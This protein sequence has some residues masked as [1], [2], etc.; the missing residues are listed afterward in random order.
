WF[1]SPLTVIRLQTPLMLMAL[2]LTLTI[3]RSYFLQVAVL[4]GLSPFTVKVSPSWLVSTWT[5]SAGSIGVGV[6]LGV[7]VG[8]GVPENLSISSFAVPLRIS[9]DATMAIDTEITV[10]S[11]SF[12][13]RLLLVIDLFAS[14]LPNNC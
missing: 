10:A 2:L 12:I 14:N 3:T 8:V 4:F 5:A 1:P 9:H 7:I 6:G 11:N 13:P